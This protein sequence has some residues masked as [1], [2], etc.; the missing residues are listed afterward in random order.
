[1]AALQHLFAVLVGVLAQLLAQRGDGVVLVVERVAEQEQA[2]LLGGE[3]E[4]EPHHHRERGLVELLLVCAGE[5]RSVAVLVHA[6][7]RLDQHLDGLADLV[8][9]LVGDLLL[10][11][12]A[13]GVA[14]PRACRLRPRRRSDGRRAG[15]GRRAA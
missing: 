9:E 13:L 10:V 14:A 4:D 5:Q 2:A 3:E 1:M 11:L 15:C 6:V 7:E 12:G 8:A